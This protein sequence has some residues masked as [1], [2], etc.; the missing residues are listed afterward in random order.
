ME[1]AV[2]PLGQQIDLCLTWIS[3]CLGIKVLQPGAGLEKDMGKFLTLL[4]DALFFRADNFFSMLT[5][6]LPCFPLLII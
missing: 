4:Y 1:K 2:F 3:L 6:C 5:C